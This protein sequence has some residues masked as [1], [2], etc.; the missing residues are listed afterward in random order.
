MRYSGLQMTFLPRG[1]LAHAALQGNPLVQ[2]EF[3]AEVPWLL[4]EPPDA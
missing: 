3:Q 4:S 1:D 2:L